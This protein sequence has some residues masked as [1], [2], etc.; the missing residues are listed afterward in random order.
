M[1]F[2]EGMFHILYIMGLVLAYTIVSLFLIITVER[3]HLQ[4]IDQFI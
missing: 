3:G 1:E 4:I 2:M